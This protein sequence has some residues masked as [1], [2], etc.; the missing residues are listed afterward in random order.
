MEWRNWS[1]ISLSKKLQLLVRFDFCWPTN[2]S[3]L[4]HRCDAFAG[5]FRINKSLQDEVFFPVSFHFSTSQSH[6]HTPT[7]DLTDHARFVSLFQ[8]INQKKIAFHGTPCRGVPIDGFKKSKGMRKKKF[9]SISSQHFADCTH[10]FKPWLVKGHAKWCV[11]TWQQ[12]HNYTIYDSPGGKR[13]IADI[14][15]FFSFYFCS[16]YLVFN[17][18]D[19]KKKIYFVEYILTFV[20]ASC[21]SNSDVVFAWVLCCWILLYF[22]SS[23]VVVK[24]TDLMWNVYR[25]R[26]RATHNTQHRAISQDGTEYRIRR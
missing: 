11:H 9:F 10:L 23:V 5:N 26:C 4:I 20:S 19:E 1:H 6:F 16:F 21:D 13:H 3:K 2:V 17:E 14:I 25:R 15:Y 24:R 8:T 18:N 7:E 22:F 12:T